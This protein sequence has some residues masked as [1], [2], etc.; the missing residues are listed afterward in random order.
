MAM[1][2]TAVEPLESVWARLHGAADTHR[3]SLGAAMFD[4]EHP[5]SLEGLLQ[6]ASLD[7]TPTAMIARS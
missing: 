4:P 5:V 2:E 6:Q 1:I 3:I 7:M